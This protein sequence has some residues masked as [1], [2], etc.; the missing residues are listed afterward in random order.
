MVP[1]IKLNIQRA[2]RNKGPRYT[3]F[4]LLDRVDKDTPIFRYVS[5]SVPVDL[6]T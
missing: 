6:L 1:R 3:I 2:E 5:K 4:G